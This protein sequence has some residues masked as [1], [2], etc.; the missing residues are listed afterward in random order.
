MGYEECQTEMC[1][2]GALLTI[3]SSHV[4]LIQYILQPRNKG[5]DNSEDSEDSSVA[6]VSSIL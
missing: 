5:A 2:S 3:Y 1:C 4:M 6:E